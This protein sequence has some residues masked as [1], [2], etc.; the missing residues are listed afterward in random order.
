[1]A[2]TIFAPSHSLPLPG[3]SAITAITAQ[4]TLGVNA[5]QGIDP[6]VLEAQIKACWDDIPPR[7]FKSGMLY[8]KEIILALV[9]A[10]QRNVTADRVPCSSIRTTLCH[11]RVHNS[12]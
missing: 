3:T 9:R 2:S 6:N 12:G 4:N 8:S 5:V 10:L 1:M 11:A 7:A